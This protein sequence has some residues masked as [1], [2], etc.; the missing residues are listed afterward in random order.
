[1]KII[2]TYK[3]ENRFVTDHQKLTRDATSPVM[4]V[5]HILTI[6]FSVLELGNSH[7]KKYSPMVICPFNL[8]TI[9]LLAISGSIYLKPAFEDKPSFSFSFSFSLIIISS[10]GVLGFK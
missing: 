9:E 7:Q 3:Y 5:R 2:I 10:T 4:I 1:M 6:F 8:S